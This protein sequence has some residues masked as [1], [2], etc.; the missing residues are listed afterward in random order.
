VKQSTSRRPLAIG[1]HIH[2]YCGGY[3]GRDHYKCGVV[4]AIGPDWVV[5]RTVLNWR[6][7]R[8]AY[9]ATGPNVLIDLA[10]YRNNKECSFFDMYHIDRCMGE[11]VEW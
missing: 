11:K 4:E 2:G 10:E 6:E 3:F 9:A 8:G 1:D 7:D 5:F